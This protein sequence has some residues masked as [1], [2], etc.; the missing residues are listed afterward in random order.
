[1][2]MFLPA[3]IEHLVVLS[4]VFDLFSKNHIIQFLLRKKSIEY[5][6]LQITQKPLTAHL[7]V[8]LEQVETKTFCS[9]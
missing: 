7:N 2:S 6:F 1:M 3:L 5:D 8:Q 4:M 9:F